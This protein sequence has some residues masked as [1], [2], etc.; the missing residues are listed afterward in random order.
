MV[1]TVVPSGLDFTFAVPA[2]GV[3][4]KVAGT[5]EVEF[6][7]DKA[8]TFDFTC[9]SCEDWRGMKGTLVVE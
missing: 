6:V 1:V 2:L 7:A 8:G 3:E 5:T 4:Q 9:G